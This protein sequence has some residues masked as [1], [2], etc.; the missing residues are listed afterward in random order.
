[1]SSTAHIC[2]AVPGRIGFRIPNKRRDTA[3][4]CRLHEK[5]SSVQ[6]IEQVNVNP[7]TGSLLLQYSGDLQRIMEQIKQSRLFEVA[8]KAPINEGSLAEHAS[9][10]LQALNEQIRARSAGGLDFWSLVFLTLIGMTAV[11]LAKGN[12]MV[13][14][15]TLLWYALATLLISRQ[16][17]SAV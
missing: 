11:R 9:A 1:V 17:V 3:Y 7:L 8:S 14:A 12:I 6:C 10:S 13:P 16:G 15:T 5:F 2:H 4:F